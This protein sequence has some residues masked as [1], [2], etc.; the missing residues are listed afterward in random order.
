MKRLI[1]LVPCIA[2]F[3]GAARADFLYSFKS[4][5]SSDFSFI[6]HELLTQ[7]TTILH[8][9][10]FD[11]INYIPGESLGSVEVYSPLGLTPQ[12]ILFYP[13]GGSLSS[14]TWAFGAKFDHAGEYFNG[15]NK[16]EITAVPEPL[17]IL[18]LATLT[19]IVLF[20]PK[21]RMGGS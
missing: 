15:F 16:L 6:E 21:T 18:L 2:F 17:S 4:A 20:V 10:L 1:S 8:A 13:G 12:L 3:C 7:T 14:I 11:V 9:D 5:S 19:G